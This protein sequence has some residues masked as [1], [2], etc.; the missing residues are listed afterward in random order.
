MRVEGV[1]AEEEDVGKL[2]AGLLKLFEEDAD[3]DLA[4][5]DALG[6]DAAGVVEGDC[7]LGA[8]ADEL[9]NRVMGDGVGDG[10]PDAASRSGTGLAVELPLALMTRVR[11]GGLRRPSGR[12]TRAVP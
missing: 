7:D 6:L 4:E 1:G 12:R 2:Y 11:S 9:V 3:G 8:L 10:L 5:V